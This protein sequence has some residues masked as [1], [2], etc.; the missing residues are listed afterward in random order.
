MHGKI[1]RQVHSIFLQDF[2]MLHQ[3]QGLSQHF[4]AWNILI[5]KFND[6]SWSVEIRNTRQLRTNSHEISRTIGAA[7]KW[8]KFEQGRLADR[9]MLYTAVYMLQ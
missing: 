9:L 6:F 8:S 7:T 5:F 3:D 2:F 1:A 4:Q